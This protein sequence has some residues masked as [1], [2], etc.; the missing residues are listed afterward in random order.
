MPVQTGVADCSMALELVWACYGWLVLGVWR[1]QGLAG[2]CLIDLGTVYIQGKGR[3]S[4]LVG[5]YIQVHRS[6]WPQCAVL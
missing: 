5:C 1:P 6:E 2:T 4:E 3:Q